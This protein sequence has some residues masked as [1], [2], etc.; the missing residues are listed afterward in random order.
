MLRE[1]NGR[2]NRDTRGLNSQGLDGL[3]TITAAT[4]CSFSLGTACSEPACSEPL[5]AFLPA[6]A[7]Q[8]LRQV[9]LLSA[10]YQQGVNLPRIIPLGSSRSETEPR[11]DCRAHSENLINH[12]QSFQVA[13]FYAG[14][15]GQCSS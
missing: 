10:L 6:R 2:L 11:S 15:E 1:E 5:H 9:L 12:P 4:V 13:V 7:Q 8:P 14:E 3:E